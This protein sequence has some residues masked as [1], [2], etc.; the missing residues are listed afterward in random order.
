MAN[1]TQDFER[2]LLGGLMKLG[3]SQSDLANHIFSELKPSS[4]YNPVYKEIY[5]AIIKLNAKSA[6]FD[7]LSVIQALKDSQL[8]KFTDIDLC[9]EYRADNSLL[10]EYAKK[11][12]DAAI[13]RFVIS[14]MADLQDLIS[15]STQGTIQERVGLAES[16]LNGL[17]E[18]IQGREEKGLKNAS[19]LASEWLDTIEEHHSGNIS[20]FDLGIESLDKIMK[21]KQIKPGSLIVVG[22]RPKMGKTFFLT[23]VARHYAINRNETACLFS[24]EMNDTDLWERM[25]SAQAQV[26]SDRFYSEPL[27]Y[28]VWDHIGQANAE[29]A[30]T[31]LHIDD[32][33]GNTIKNIKAEVRKVHR[34]DPVKMIG[35]DY[36][37][38]MNTGDEER[39]DLKYAAITKE[40]KK[41]AKELGCIIVLLIQLNRSLESRPNKRPIPSDG[42]DTGQIEQDCD[43]WIGLYRE[44]VY[45][46]NCGHQLTEAII[47]LNRVGA[48]GTAYMTLANGYFEDVSE[49]E[50]NKLMEQ[51]KDEQ[52]F[53]ARRN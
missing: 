11:I 21:P 28:P 48:S 42:R 44:A 47:R 10:R 24:M 26:N 31:K 37:T 27:N 33:A 36:L 15:D 51:N 20:N 39:N 17:I 13:E 8:V 3:N 1:N 38:L 12:K 45:N 7:N 2:A 43:V 19:Q 16:A 52:Q 50:A 40:L 46:E 5:K 22:A 9:Y 35:I 18:S 29:L 4:F 49:V 32:R 53:S 23:T 25:V 14:K 30:N 41:L 34:Q 6:Y